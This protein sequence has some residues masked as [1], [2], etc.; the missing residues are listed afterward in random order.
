M[1]R[2]LIAVLAAVSLAACEGL[3]GSRLPDVRLNTVSAEE[4]ESLATCPTTKCLT[5]YVAP[6][7]GV[8]RS[9]TSKIVALKNLLYE[10]GGTMRVVVGM[11]TP[12][13]VAEYAR[14]FGPDSLVDPGG[15]IQTGGVPHFWVT[16]ASGAVIKENSGIPEVESADELADFFGLN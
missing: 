14:E 5:V 9:A 6:W 1:T 15:T 7:C 4:G 12:E 10:R 13:A 2:R 3:A 16:D 8:C 11:D